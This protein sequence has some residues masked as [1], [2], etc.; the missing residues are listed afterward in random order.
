MTARQPP[1]RGCI[2]ARVSENSMHAMLPEGVRP[3]R[4]LIRLRRG[5][6]VVRRRPDDPIVLALFHDVG[7]PA[8]D[9]GQRKRRGEELLGNAQRKIDDAL[10]ELEIGT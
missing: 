8:E 3:L 10:V 4:K 6:D 7:R 2:D 9:A 1:S 5:S